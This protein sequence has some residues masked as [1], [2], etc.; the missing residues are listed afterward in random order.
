MNKISEFFK[1]GYILIILLLFYLPLFFMF[2][3]SFNASSSKGYINFSSWNGFSWDAY[4]DLF[5][6]EI[7]FS[8]MNSTILAIV[9]SF[10][11]IILS[12]LTVF[13]IWKQKNKTIKVVKNISSNIS[14]VLP[15]IIIGISLV[16][17]F[18]LAFGS[19][20]SNEEGFW[21]AV[22]SHVVMILPYGVLIMYPKSEK[23]K[24]TMFEASYDLGYPVIK[25]W[26]KTYF[27]YMLS[28]IN[29]TLIISIILSFDDFIITRI[30]SNMETVGTELYQ[31]NFKSWAL[32]LGS[33]FIV[34]IFI[35]NIVY[36]IKKNKQERK[37]I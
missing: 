22:I 14:M 11:V 29:F 36:F 2:I 27:V 25:T 24:K 9:V 18:G 34:I 6:S 10:I 33:I 26:F 12:L 17:F 7:M 5:S 35:G 13:S 16:S 21:N 20:T 28:S 30:V 32:A 4:R 19:L 1:K 31:G 23:F 37:R 3:F 15:D 8:F